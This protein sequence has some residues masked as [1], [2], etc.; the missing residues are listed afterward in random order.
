MTGGLN[1]V[2]CSVEFK[3]VFML[4]SGFVVS[5]HSE[6]ILHC[7]NLIVDASV[8]AVLVSQVVQLLTQFGYQLVFVCSSDFYASFLQAL[9]LNYL[10]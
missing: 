6:P 1:L 2:Y 4:A 5:Q 10:S 8:V 7:E 9:N 3:S